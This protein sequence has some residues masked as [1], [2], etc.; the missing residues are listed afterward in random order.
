MMEKIYQGGGMKRLLPFI[1][2]VLLFLV[3]SCGPSSTNII[4]TTVVSQFIAPVASTSISTNIPE[5]DN[6]ISIINADLSNASPLGWIM[7]AQY[8]MIDVTFQ[9]TPKKTD[10]IA[11][12][13]VD[14]MC[15]NSTNCC[16][17]ERTFV[18]VVESMRKNYANVPLSAFERVGEF[19][20]VCSDLKTKIE[21][22]VVSASWNEV[23]AYLENPNGN[24][25][26]LGGHAVRLIP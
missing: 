18:V 14:C 11:L 22:G 4:D 20:V 25:H 19:R 16:I 1:P 12:V 8:Y 13:H 10:L 2:I 7:D 9:D 23:K 26:Q 5:I 21:I 15:M 3:N 24:K 6:M 17:P